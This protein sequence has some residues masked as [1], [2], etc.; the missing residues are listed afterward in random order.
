MEYQLNF[1]FTDSF[2]VCFIVFVSTNLC[3][4]LLGDIPPFCMLLT[5]TISCFVIDSCPFEKFIIFFAIA[6]DDRYPFRSRSIYQNAAFY[7]V[8][9]FSYFAQPR[10]GGGGGGTHTSD[11]V[12]SLT[13]MWSKKIME[14]SEDVF[15][16]RDCSKAQLHVSR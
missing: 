5:L 12:Q 9:H 3:G 15:N 11:G 16:C 8:I 2:C 13:R 4:S 6:T 1:F 10:G 14:S 7:L